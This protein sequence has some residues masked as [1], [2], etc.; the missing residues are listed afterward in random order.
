MSQSM[1]TSVRGAPDDLPH[2]ARLARP[3]SVRV[4]SVNEIQ[5]KSCACVISGVQCRDLYDS[6]RLVE[7]VDVALAEVRPLFDARRWRR[8]RSTSFR[9]RFE[10]RVAPEVSGSDGQRNA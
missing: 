7:D 3:D 10:D 1:N 6:F 5:P 9:D 8:A 4:Y 2:L